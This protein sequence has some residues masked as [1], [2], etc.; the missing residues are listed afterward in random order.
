MR[1]NVLKWILF[2]ALSLIWGS[3]FILM[4]LG[5]N[6]LSAFQVASLRITA[7][8]LVMLPMALK[9]FRSIPRNKLAPVFFSGVLGSLLPSYLFCWAET[10]IDSSLAG[11]LNAL[12][13]IFTILTG[14]LFFQLRTTAQKVIGIV[15]A[16]SGCMILFFNEAMLSENEQYGYLFFVL[17]ATVSYGLNVNLVHQYLKDIPSL[18]IVA[19]AMTL[20]AIPAL[21][22]LIGTGYFSMKMSG[23]FTVSTGYALLLGA[24][25]TSLAN[26]L[27]YILIKKAG[28]LF[29]SM[30]TYGIPFVAFGWGWIVQEKLSWMQV[31][32]LFVILAGV[33]IAN[34]SPFLS[35]GGSKEQKK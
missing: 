25:G 13:P 1:N 27:F 29:A 2:L 22:V 30:V 28:S 11:A 17:V 15:V 31:L 12:T 19:V 32:A 6:A 3:S 4:K 18:Q 20:C 23:Q 14:V 10:G 16:F 8:G 24:V 7:S 21:G 35:S 33:Y 5:M 9:S 26:I 34:A